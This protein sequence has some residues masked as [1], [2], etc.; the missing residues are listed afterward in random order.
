MREMIRHHAAGRI[1]LTLLMSLVLM[2]RIVAPVGF[3]PAAT[4]TSIAIQICDGADHASRIML[5]RGIPVEKHDAA[6]KPCAFGFGPAAFDLLIATP[7]PWL[8]VTLA[9]APV[10]VMTFGPVI[11]GLAAPPPPAIGPPTLR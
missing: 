6:D 1:F 3:M 5:D 4:G 10:V 9:S 2:V 7:L 8:L 11:P